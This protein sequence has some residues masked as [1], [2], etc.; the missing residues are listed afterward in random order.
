MR[1]YVSGPMTGHPELNYPA[2]HAAAHALTRAGHDVINPA[3][4]GVI[5][6]W[7]WRD[8]MR[9]AVRD[10]ADAQALAMLP[11]WTDS[12]GARLE[13]RIA[14]GLGLPV[15]PLTHWLGGAVA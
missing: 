10:V 2:F 3:R 13:R 11:G 1:I 14:R 8:Y 15:H 12:R 7:D 5:P 4:W 6:G 9:H